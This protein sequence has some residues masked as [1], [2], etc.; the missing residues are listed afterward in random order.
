MG[1]TPLGIRLLRMSMASTPVVAH[2]VNVDEAGC[3]WLRIRGI[4][5][6]VRARCAVASAAL[7]PRDQVVGAEVVVVLEDGDAGRPII[8][9]FVRES[10]WGHA[11]SATTLPTVLIEGS[12]EVALR[13]GKAS[14]SLAADGRIVIKGT[15]L[16]SRATEANKVRG[17][18]VLIN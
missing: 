11:A 3:A 8:M 9:G 17:A 13:C 2:V 12:D 14:I 1:D 18:V 4:D 10:L 6:P 15:R 5:E 16:T 7:P